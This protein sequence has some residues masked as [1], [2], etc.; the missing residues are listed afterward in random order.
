M[1][2][3]RMKCGRGKEKPIGQ[4]FKYSNDEIHFFLR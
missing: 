2:L 4:S 3:I 1:N